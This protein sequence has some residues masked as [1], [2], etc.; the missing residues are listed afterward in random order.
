M[1]LR[2]V[3]SGALLICRPILAFILCCMLLLVCGCQKK[4][5]MSVNAS[6]CTADTVVFMEY[7]VENLF[8]MI[9]NGS[10][11]PEFKPNTCNWTN[12]THAVKRDN[13]ASVIVAAHPGIAV[14]LEIENE[15]SLKDLLFA[16]KKKNCEYPY[17]VIEQ[18]QG[19]RATASAIISCLPIHKHVNNAS[20][21][22]A[23]LEA[24]VVW[25]KETLDVFACHWPSKKY[26]ESKRIS[27]AVALKNRLKQLPRAKDYVI[28]GDM[29]ENYDECVTFG[30]MGFDNTHGQ[31]GLNHVLGTTT[32][33][34]NAQ[35]VEYQTKEGILAATGNVH[36]DPWLDISESKRMSETFR[37]QYQ[38]PDH[39]LLP[40]SMFDTAG[41][42]YVDCSFRVFTWNKR[43]LYYG[44]PY[45]WQMRFSGKQK[46]HKGEGYSD[47]LPLI[48]Q[49]RRKPFFGNVGTQRKKAGA[50]KTGVQVNAGFETG[51]DGWVAC[52]PKIHAYRDSVEPSAGRYCL[53]ITGQAGK[54][55]NT[56]AKVLLHSSTT[57]VTACRLHIQGSGEFSFR[58]RPSGSNI[59]TYYVGPEFKLSKAGKYCDYDFKPWTQI[60]LPISDS[61]PRARDYELE[62]RA[63]K[64]SNL[65]IR[66][67]RVV[68]S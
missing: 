58:M 62:L 1:T 59:W 26:P 16:L 43:L 21:N 55:N 24:D 10:E 47:H 34:S 7:N 14:L 2:T 9:N 4:T 61:L 32:I 39:I 20:G 22:S 51:C 45:R 18:K 6:V 67:D 50:V 38:T 46:F 37:H 19:S 54:Q 53:K 13:I 56:A 41:I 5:A 15:N 63:K 64:D 23:F 35:H 17:Y 28:A 49:L 27:S 48:V 30:T 65:R 60:T 57:E 52:E 11:Y 31:T 33:R 36:F 25:G 3:Y 8:D 29:N 40:R 68:L 12:A 42:S 66:L 44:Q